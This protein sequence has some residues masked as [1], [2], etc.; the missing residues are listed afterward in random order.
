MRSPGDFRVGNLNFVEHDVT[1]TKIIIGII[2]T[3]GCLE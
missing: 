1:E 3:N 2:N